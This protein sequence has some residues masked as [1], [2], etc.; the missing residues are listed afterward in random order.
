MLL[1]PRITYLS[2]LWHV[3]ATSRFGPRAQC[4]CARWEMWGTWRQIRSH[5]ACTKATA[6]EVDDGWWCILAAD[7]SMASSQSLVRREGLLT[8]GGIDSLGL[9]TAVAVCSQLALERRDPL[10]APSIYLSASHAHSSLQ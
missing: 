7:A 6:G 1:T 9:A 4:P 2:C 10:M 5:S 8:N 3:A